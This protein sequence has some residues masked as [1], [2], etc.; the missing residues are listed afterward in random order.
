[1][2]ARSVL[3]LAT[4]PMEIINQ[5]A[6]AEALL[7]W[8]GGQESALYA[9]GSCMLSDCLHK[10]P[11]NPRNHRGHVQAVTDAIDELR[12]IRSRA[13]YLEAVTDDDVMEAELLADRLADLQ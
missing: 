8:H 10:R 5:Q 9:V 3:G 12:H 4:R 1:M 7:R 6:L 11:Y 13:T 2:V